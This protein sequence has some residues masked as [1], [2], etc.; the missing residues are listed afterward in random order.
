MEELVLDLGVTKISENTAMSSASDATF[1]EFAAHGSGDTLS[2]YEVE[3]QVIA[4]W[5]QLNELK[6]EQ[7][8]LEAQV[9]SSGERIGC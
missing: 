7:A 3:G 9:S 8:V 1:A 4:L 2:F 5:D 6:L